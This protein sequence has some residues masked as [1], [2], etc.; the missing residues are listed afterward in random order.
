MTDEESMTRAQIDKVL[1]EAESEK[2]LTVKVVDGIKNY[3]L[4]KKGRQFLANRS[5]YALETINFEINDGGLEA[6]RHFVKTGEKDDFVD[7][8]IQKLL[9]FVLDRLERGMTGEEIRKEIEDEKNAD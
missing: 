3:F 8:T 4:N 9:P 7:Q 5:I 6:F 2:T 1:D